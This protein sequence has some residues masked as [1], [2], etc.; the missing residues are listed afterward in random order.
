MSNVADIPPAAPAPPPSDLIWMSAAE[1]TRRF[2]DRTLSPVEVASA[3]LDRIVGLNEKLNAFCLVD[4]GGALSMAEAS[5]ARWRAEDPLGPLDGV[6][7][8]VKDVVLARGW[9]TLRGSLAVDAAQV[10]DQDSPVVAR[11]RDSGA[12]LLGKTTTPEFGWKAVTDSPLTGITRNPWDSSKTPGGSSG[13]ASAAIAAGMGPLAI[14]SDGGGSIRIPASF[15]GCYG[16]KPTFGRIPAW[17]FSP[18][19]TLSHHGPLS[20]TVADA[21]TFLQVTAQPD[22]RDWY[23]LPPTGDDFTADLSAGVEGLRIAFSPTLGGAQVDPEVAAAVAV[24]ARQFAEMGAHVEEDEPAFGGVPH[25]L[26][27]YTK[28]WYAGAAKLYR[29]MDADAQARVDPGLR[30]VAEAGDAYSLAT[31]QDAVEARQTLGSVAN[32]FL[33]EYDLLLTPTMPIAAFEAGHEVPPGSGMPRWPLWSPFS[34]PF[35]LTQ[36]PAATIPCG[37]TDAGLPI[38]LQIVGSLFGERLVLRASAAYERASPP[39]RCPV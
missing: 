33:E 18:F 25:V 31:Y 34:Y 15:A 3:V 28:H 10:W 22:S 32:A 29:E 39:P 7:I 6:P 30:E 16:I 1:M 21:A 38:G 2:A 4:G 12:V 17:P 8:S 5:E 9:P 36:Q 35:N 19:G 20:R 24:A 13:G 11:L 23:A 27:I 14:G 26:D 37:L